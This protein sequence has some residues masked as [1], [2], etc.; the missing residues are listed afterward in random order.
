MSLSSYHALFLTTCLTF[1][2]LQTIPRASRLL[3][4]YT[5][6]SLARLLSVYGTRY[7][8]YTVELYLPAW[9]GLLLAV[10][11]HYY[12]DDTWLGVDRRSSEH[13]HC[14]VQPATHLYT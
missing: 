4:A 7:Q 8:P 6:S 1:M 14:S 10:C 13:D 2:C 9:R 11:N 12:M 3:A 5:T